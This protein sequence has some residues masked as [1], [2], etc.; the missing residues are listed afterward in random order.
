[1]PPM[2]SALGRA[3]ASQTIAIL[4]L[5]IAVSGTAYAVATKNS[6]VSS[7]IKNGQVKTKDLANNAVKPRKLAPGAVSG[8]K[9]ADGSLTGADIDEDSLSQ[10]PAAAVAG[11]AGQ[12]WE[13][14]T[15]ACTP[16]NTTTYEKCSELTIELPAAARLVLIGQSGISHRVDNQYEAAGYCRFHV[17]GTPGSATPVSKNA[18]NQAAG[19]DSYTPILDTVAA[20]AGPV[21][22]G[23][24]CVDNYYS[25]F[26]NVKF[27]ALSVAPPT[28]P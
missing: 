27:V 14:N 16:A 28:A 7:S 6:V 22:I 13:S 24:W 12:A 4:A 21:T 19:W 26:A 5:C 20:P 9:V 11:L 25:K 18:G 17:N 2:I 3:I 10:V 1:M 15:G 8:S 23:I